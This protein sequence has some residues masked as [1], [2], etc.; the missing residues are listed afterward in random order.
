MG[1]RNVFEAAHQCGV[2]R[3]VLASSIMVSWGYQQD[4]PYKAISEGRFAE[5]DLDKYPMVTH[6]S[7]PRPTGLY[8]ASKVWAEALARYYADIHHLSFCVC[9]LV[10]LMLKTILAVNR[11]GHF[12]VVKETLFSLY[13]GRLKRL[14]PCSSIFFTVFLIT[15]GVG[16]TSNIQNVL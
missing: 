6:E 9:V 4:E 16:L 14:I 12:G 5:V 10:G 3:V 7:A 2:R 1:V 11:A 8:P 15:D 13:S